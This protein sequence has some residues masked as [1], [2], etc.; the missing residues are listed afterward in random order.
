MI[1]GASGFLG[2]N[3]CRAALERWEVYGLSRRSR[4]RIEGIRYLNADLT[5]FRV[6]KQ[7]LLEI[8]PD[9]LIHAAAESSPNSCQLNPQASH[10]INVEAALN[11]ASFC[12]DLRIP[13]VFISSDLVFDGMKPPYSENDTV[14]PISVYGEQK[15]EAE[16]VVL[17][18]H[19]RALV[20][21]TALMFGDAGQEAAS[22]IQ[23]MISDMKNGRRISLFT[24]EYRTPLS[25]EN[26][27]QGIL[28]A[29]FKTN[30]ILHMAGPERI[31]RLDFGKLLKDV[32]GENNAGLSPCT[33]QS[34]TMPAPRPADVS[35]DI[36][37]AAALGFKPGSL[38]DELEKLDCVRKLRD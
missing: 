35:L 1:T 38:R 11:L 6:V 37:R 31:S 29:L 5:D 23:P 16:R 12:A 10:R 4:N 34:I 32:L 8:R 26:A 9:A 33:R 3:L 24:D 28:L 15:A 13:F 2:W 20:C 18:S 27:A 22:F 36:S 19:P 7:K 25:A 30:G 17:K 21:R 14:S